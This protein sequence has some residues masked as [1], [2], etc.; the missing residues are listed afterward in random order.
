MKRTLLILGVGLLAATLLP[1]SSRAV[2]I[3]DYNSSASASGFTLTGLPTD[4]GDIGTLPTLAA[5]QS[6]QVNTITVARLNGAT[7]GGLDVG[8]FLWNTVDPTSTT[9]VFSNLLTS[10]SFNRTVTGTTGVNTTNINYAAGALTLQSGQTFGY[11]MVYATP[12]SIN[13]ATAAYTPTT[14][15]SSAFFINQGPVTPS[16]TSPDTFYSDANSDGK[17]VASDLTT[18]GQAGYSNVYLVINATI[19]PE[20]GTNAMLALSGLALVGI[21]L[22]RRRSAMV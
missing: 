18:L 2:V 6:Y 20:P 8:F 11:Q 3:Y 14:T 1:V 5:G 22:V 4:V 16:G 17:L 12:G 7:A 13:L 15:G 21:W 9:S 10:T 19:V